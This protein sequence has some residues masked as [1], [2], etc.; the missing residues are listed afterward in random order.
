MTD[1]E[2]IDNQSLLLT[3][4]L[5]WTR[6]NGVELLIDEGMYHPTNYALAKA[7]GEDL[8]CYPYMRGDQTLEDFIL[9]IAG[10]FQHEC[11]CKN[12][13][14]WIDNK[15]GSKNTELEG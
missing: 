11:L 12:V 4:C 2:Y 5:A 6:R 3:Y 15:R 14:S 13:Y 8:N 9:G 1:E 10:Q 7:I